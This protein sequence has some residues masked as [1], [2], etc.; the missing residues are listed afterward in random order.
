MLHN[1]I[2]TICTTWQYNTI[3]LLH[4]TNMLTIVLN[5][6]PDNGSNNGN[7]IDALISYDGLYILFNSHILV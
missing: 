5:H 2:H 1:Y 6:I 3:I 4:V 7:K